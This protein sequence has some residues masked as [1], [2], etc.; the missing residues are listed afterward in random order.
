MTYKRWPAQALWECENCGSTGTC[1]GV[2]VRSAST[3]DD[4]GEADF[5]PEAHENGSLF[6]GC[7]ECMSQSVY[8]DDVR[9]QEPSSAAFRRGG[10]L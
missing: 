1:T 7:P 9:P 3:P 10:C 6:S 2:V 5:Y 4:P 8:F